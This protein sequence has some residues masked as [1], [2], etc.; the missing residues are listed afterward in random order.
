MRRSTARCGVFFASQHRRFQLVQQQQFDRVDAIS[1]FAAVDRRDVERDADLGAPR[2]GEYV[3]D[4]VDLVLHQQPTVAS[5][6]SD[7]ARDVV[8]LDVVVRAGDD[9]DRVFT[10]RADLNHRVAGRVRLRSTA[11]RRRRRPRRPE[12]PMS[13]VPS[14]PTQPKCATR[15]PARAAAS[16]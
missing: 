4:V 2:L 16:D 15:A 9:D 5:D 11:R 6:A 10:V 7:G 12:D 14:T 13:Q 3:V 1:G 8:G